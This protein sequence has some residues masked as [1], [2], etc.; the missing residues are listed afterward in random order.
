[1]GRIKE[2]VGS[3]LSLVSTSEVS[4]PNNHPKDCKGK[5]GRHVSVQIGHDDLLK[6]KDSWV[7]CD[8]WD[9]A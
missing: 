4:H 6:I 3:S 9:C 5:H 8:S 1:M 2:S 7:R